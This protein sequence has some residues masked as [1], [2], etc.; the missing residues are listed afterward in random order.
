[1]I[2][3]SQ[4]GLAAPEREPAWDEWY[5]THLQVMLT[6]SGIDSTQRFKTES[7]GW[8]P[9]L[10][11]YTVASAAVFSDAHYQKIRGMGEWAPLI[12][13]AHYHRNLFEGREV[14]PE[15]GED[16][17]LLVIDRPAPQAI[18]GIAV[19]WL[20]AAGLDRSTPY[21]GIAVV[22]RAVIGRIECVDGTVIYAPV[23]P[24]RRT[25]RK[26]SQP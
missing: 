22:K 25:N 14:A 9:S 19:D 17:A 5:E 18:A 15:V 3:M 1:M 8:P 21:R 23:T 2:F 6:V 11:M 20:Q 13:R 7:A 16:E 10:A 26:R 24:Y 12:V 4:S